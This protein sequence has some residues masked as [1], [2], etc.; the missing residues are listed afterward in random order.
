MHEHENLLLVSQDLA[1]HVVADLVVHVH[2]LATNGATLLL[3]GVFH[4]DEFLAKWDWS[5]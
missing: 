3:Y 2:L 1:E 5:V 4:T